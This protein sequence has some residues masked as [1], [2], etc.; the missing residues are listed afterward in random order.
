MTRKLHEIAAEILEAQES[1]GDMS[2]DSLEQALSKVFATLLQRIKMAKDGGVLL[3]Q[4]KPP[5]QQPAQESISKKTDAK[6]SIRRDK[7]IC[8]ECQA[9]MRQLTAKHLGSHG[10]TIREYKKKYGFPQRQSLAAKSLSEA[11][12]KAAKK[13][14]LPE[15]LRQFQEQRK[16]QKMETIMMASADTTSAPLDNRE[17]EAPAKRGRKK[18]TE[19]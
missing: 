14:G 12:S 13:R 16:Q 3:D 5:E 1:L 18:K 2:L 11:R 10:L 19:K 4:A 17:N 7:V 9:E 15:K 8:L 6:S